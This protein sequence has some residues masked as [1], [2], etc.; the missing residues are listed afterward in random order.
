M[1]EWMLVW[2]DP[3]LVE[4]WSLIETMLFFVVVMEIILWTTKYYIHHL[5]PLTSFHTR[6]GY[7]TFNEMWGEFW[8]TAIYAALLFVM[9]VSSYFTLTHHAEVQSTFDCV[10]YASGLQSC[11]E[12]NKTLACVNVRFNPYTGGSEWNSTLI[13]PFNGSPVNYSRQP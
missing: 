2:N 3:F 4:R 6:V 1:L 11:F 10:A 7:S 13:G 12:Q 9:A 8:R 5:S